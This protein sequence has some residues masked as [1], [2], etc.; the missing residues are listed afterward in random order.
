MYKFVISTFGSLGDIYPY[1]AIGLELKK[2][3][4]NVIIATC[5]DY[6]K[7]I[8]EI[9]LNFSPMRP[10]MPKDKQLLKEGTDLKKGSETIVKK[11]VIPEIESS[12]SDLLIAAKD[13]DILI[14]HSFCYAGPIVADKLKLLWVSGV[15]APSG[16]WSVYDPSVIALN[17]FMYKV[18]SYGVLVNKILYN[19]IRKSVRSWGKPIY[20][21]RRKMGLGPGGDPILEG[22]RSPH[23][24]LALF[25][26]ELAKRQVDWPNQMHITGF[27]FLEK[28]NKLD[29]SLQKFIEEGEPPIVFTLGSLLPEL[30][31]DTFY[32][33]SYEIMTKLN[34]RCI[35][36]VG[37]SFQY[38]LDQA[39]P[40]HIYV[41]KYVELRCLLDKALFVV[42]HGGIGST[43]EAL[44][45]GCPMLIIPFC[46]DQ[47]D[48]AARLEKLGVAKVLFKVDYSK[49][50]FR[51]K[52]IEMIDDKGLV[53]KAKFISKR[54]GEEN[55]TINA[56]DIIENFLKQELQVL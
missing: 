4:H 3:G 40:E 19:V 51:K 22:K 21:L 50:R 31:A 37:N 27:S 11:W 33:D 24:C 8:E 17:K 39:I 13:A 20:D 10:N 18:P 49:D 35:L 2:R 12:V 43:S 15:L 42:H 7:K 55:G 56:C 54:V 46:H 30:H 28:N 29:D 5:P 38:Y 44:K 41:A 34:K 14:N 36:L 25:S 53:N 32:S 48:N 6:C 9:G 26:K 52:L 1:L 47:P 16:V 23:L 45:A